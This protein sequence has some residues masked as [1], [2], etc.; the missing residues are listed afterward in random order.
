MKYVIGLTPSYIQRGRH[1]RDRMVVGFRITYAIS[2]R[3]ETP[4]LYQQVSEEHP[5]HM[6]AKQNY[7]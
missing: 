7:Q 1:G 5:T 6:V 3:K 4:D 2:K